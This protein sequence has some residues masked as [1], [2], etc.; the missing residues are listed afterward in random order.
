MLA[1]A[2]KSN[3]RC[4]YK[5]YPRPLV[6]ACTQFW[7]KVV[8][9]PVFLFQWFPGSI[10]AVND[11]YTYD[12]VYE[13]GDEEKNVSMSRIEVMVGSRARLL[14]VAT[15]LGNGRFKG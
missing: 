9:Y 7:C 11:D 15:T 8:C 12:I 5:L 1:I 10:A 4:I 14:F 13:D 3:A 6:A 2:S